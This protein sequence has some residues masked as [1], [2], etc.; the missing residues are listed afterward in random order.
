MSGFHLGLSC[1]LVSCRFIMLCVCVS[2][3]VCVMLGSSLVF[4]AFCYVMMGRK[5][6]SCLFYHNRKDVC[7]KRVAIP[8]L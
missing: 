1:G 8:M 7:G 2:H 4:L 5:S 6:L 3:D